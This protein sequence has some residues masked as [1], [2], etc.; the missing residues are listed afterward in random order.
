MA[1]ILRAV[2]EYNRDGALLYSVDAPGAFSRGATE[3][4]AIMKLPEEVRKFR[5]WSGMELSGEGCKVEVVQRH[6]TGLCVKDADS[7]VIFDSERAP[8]GAGEYE[9]MR[10]LVIRSAADFARLYRSLPDVETTDIPPRETFYKRIPRT[11]REMYEHT[12]GVTSYYLGEIGL[13]WENLPD[14]YENRVRALE[15]LEK[16]PDF[17]ERPALEGSYGEW[18]SLRKAMRRFLW[19]DRIHARAMYRMAVRMWGKAENIFCF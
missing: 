18:W 19:H 17:L 12:N 1:E 9:D 4:A 6:L 3:V 14:I 10:A 8:M 7:E 5:L 11:G 16:I 15:A 13:E 2:L